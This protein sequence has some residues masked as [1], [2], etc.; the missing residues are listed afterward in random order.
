[1]KNRKVKVSYLSDRFHLFWW[2]NI[3]SKGTGELGKVLCDP[4]EPEPGR[5]NKMAQ[6]ARPQDP[7][8]PE[9]PGYKYLK[10]VVES[11]TSFLFHGIH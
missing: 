6:E 4:P 10:V 2:W 11:H 8:N 1:M 7:G 9:T 5:K 3:I